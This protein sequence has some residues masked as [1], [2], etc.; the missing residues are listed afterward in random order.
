MVLPSGYSQDEEGKVVLYK[1][2]LGHQGQGLQQH[3]KIKK[4]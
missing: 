2:K 1:S 3:N 4:I